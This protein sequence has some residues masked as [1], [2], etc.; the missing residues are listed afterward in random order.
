MNCKIHMFFSLKLRSKEFFLC[1]IHL[2]QMDEQC[3]QRK[4]S[5]SYAFLR[6]SYEPKKSYK[7]V[8]LIFLKYKNEIYIY[9][10]LKKKLIY[11]KLER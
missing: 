2:N 10:R 1:S 8:R 3:H 5:Y 7:S 11:A 9:V 4:I 6:F